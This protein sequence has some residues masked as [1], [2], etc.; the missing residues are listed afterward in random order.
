MMFFF[1]G[2]GTL[3]GRVAL[4]MGARQA[5]ASGSVACGLSRQGAFVVVNS[6]Q[7]A[8]AGR[9]VSMRSA[10]TTSQPMSAIPRPLLGWSQRQPGCAVGS[11]SASVS[12]PSNSDHQAIAHADLAAATRRL[13][14]VFCPQCDQLFVLT[15]AA[16]PWLGAWHPAAG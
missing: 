16:Q 11:T 3:H 4:V 12:V 6:R 9:A 13:V 2:G 10:A 7:S 1:A 14:S 5:A 15:A 8:A